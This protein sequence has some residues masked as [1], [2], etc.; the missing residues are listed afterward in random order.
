MAKGG[1]LMKVLAINCGSSTLKF[2]VIQLTAEDIPAS[3]S[4]WLI[5]GSINRIGQEGTIKV[6]VNGGGEQNEEVAVKDY[7]EAMDLVLDQLETLGYLGPEGVEAMGH[8]VVQGADRFTKPVIIDDSV[9]QAID[10]LSELAPLHNKPSLEAIRSAW[11]SL[12]PDVPMVATFDTLF[13]LSLPDRA[14]QYPIPPELVEKH[15]IKRFGAHGLAHRYMTERYAVVTATPLE[16]VNLITLQLGSGCSATAVQKGCSVDT[17]MGLTPLEG[18]MMGTRTG[19][20]DPSLPSYLARC[21]KANIAEVEDWLNKR[22]GL[23]G[24]SGSSQDVR[25]LLEAEERGDRRAALALDMFCYRVRKYIGAYLAALGGAEAVV[26]GGGIGEN[27]P[28]IRKRICGGL[29]WLGL[30]LDPDVNHSRTGSE[31]R[32]SSDE[33][34]I[35]A[36]VLPVNEAVIIARDTVACLSQQI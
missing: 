2:Q 9:I 31:G 7:P 23:L 20:I 12:G 1:G 3:H 5:D 25:D 35:H 29:E 27:S 13:H 10:E 17:S 22:S 4:Q 21:E 11:D 32:I 15:R 24:V 30:T 26:V 16:K 6:T 14:S 18:L 19:D 28:E 34:R 36:Y 33:A 8:R